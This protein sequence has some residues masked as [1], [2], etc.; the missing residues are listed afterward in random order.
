[1]S[2]SSSPPSPSPSPPPPPPPPP[3]TCWQAF[4]RFFCGFNRNGQAVS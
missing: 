1:L 2:L 4:V 3:P